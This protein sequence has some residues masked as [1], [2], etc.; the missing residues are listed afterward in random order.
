MLQCHCT[1]ICKY[2]GLR[3]CNELPGNNVDFATGPYSDIK[4]GPD[5]AMEIGY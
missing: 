4:I 3:C 2:D 1:G 5:R